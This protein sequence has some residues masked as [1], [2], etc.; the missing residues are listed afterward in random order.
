MAI[1]TDEKLKILMDLAVENQA[2]LK[3]ILERV[4]F[5]QN[6]YNNIMPTVLNEDKLTGLFPIKSIEDLQVVE[7][8]LKLEKE[9]ESQLVSFRKV[10]SVEKIFKLF[11]PL[12]FNTF[13]RLF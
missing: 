8:K 13:V 1:T 3:T 9:F 4:N 12:L 5:M 10:N 6:N 2:I 7:E 11:T